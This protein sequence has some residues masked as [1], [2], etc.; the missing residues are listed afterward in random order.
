MP[1]VRFFP[2]GLARSR[3][4]QCGGR[5]RAAPGRR[6]QSPGIEVH[7]PVPSQRPRRA[8]AR[9]RRI[10]L[11]RGASG[12]VGEH[13]DGGRSPRTSSNSDSNGPAAITATSSRCLICRPKTTRS[14]SVFCRNTGARCR[15]TISG[16]LP[17]LSVH[18]RRRSAAA[19]ISHCAGR[20]HWRRGRLPRFRRSYDGPPNPWR[21]LS[22]PRVSGPNV[23]SAAGI[24]CRA[25][26]NG[27]SASCRRKAPDSGTSG[28]RRGTHACAV[29]RLS[30][31]TRRSTVRRRRERPGRTS[32]VTARTPNG[33]LV[34]RNPVS[35]AVMIVENRTEG[36]E[37]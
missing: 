26:V 2:G 35:R 33:N 30:L 10:V 20:A 31:A 11:V 13:V 1:A 29:S 27:S 15:A 23:H 3:R 22:A 7:R 4:G 34:W 12:T 21:R 24:R 28:L 16:R 25:A 8:H 17:A 9:A 37:S 18:A 32:I 19:R 5:F 36:A 14:S 6:G